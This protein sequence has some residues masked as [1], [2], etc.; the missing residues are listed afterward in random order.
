MAGGTGGG[1]SS[2]YI[3]LLSFDSSFLFLVSTFCF[4]IFF[5][6]RVLKSD[7]E[8]LAKGAVMGGGNAWEHDL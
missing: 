6:E 1:G 2:A 3:F 7:V 8:I 5:R 4:L